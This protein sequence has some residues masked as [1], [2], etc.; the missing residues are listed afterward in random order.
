MSINNLLKPNLYDM[1][2]HSLNFSSATGSNYMI[3]TYQSESFTLS[4]TGALIHDI[5]VTAVKIGNSATGKSFCTLNFVG[6]DAVIAALGTI[7]FSGIP[8]AYRPFNTVINRV[9]AVKDNSVWLSN[10]GT[11]KLLSNGT[12]LIGRSG[13]LEGVDPFTAGGVGYSTF[14]VS[15]IV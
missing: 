1:Y 9:G 10:S 4:L 3:D 8:A 11:I 13:L 12:G 15:Y 2:A 7:N 5:T 6:Y 14:S